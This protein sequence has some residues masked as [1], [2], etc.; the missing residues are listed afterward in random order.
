M[1]G[2]TEGHR[3]RESEPNYNIPHPE[4][5]DEQEV[6]EPIPVSKFNN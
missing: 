5:D 1:G 3:Q 4:A 2:L 6:E